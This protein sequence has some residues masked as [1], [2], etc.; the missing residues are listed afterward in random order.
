MSI[1]FGEK[2]KEHAANKQLREMSINL[3]YSIAWLKLI[4]NWQPNSF[5]CTN[6]DID[7]ITYLNDFWITK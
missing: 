3:H 1:T 5:I 6:V 2:Q 7:W 4:N